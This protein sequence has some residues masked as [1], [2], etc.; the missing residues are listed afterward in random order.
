MSEYFLFYSFI[1]IL[2]V[3][4]QEVFSLCHISTM[5][6]SFPPQIFSSFSYV[7]KRLAE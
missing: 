3:G 5:T 6:F 2:W 1:L 7:F 4:G